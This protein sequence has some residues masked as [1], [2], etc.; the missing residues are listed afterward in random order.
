MNTTLSLTQ[1]YTYQSDCIYH[2]PID[3][4]LQMDC[5][6]LVPNQS[7]NSK[8]QSHFGLI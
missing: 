4:E 2:F 3:M 1:P 8:K 6:R 7:E 5:V